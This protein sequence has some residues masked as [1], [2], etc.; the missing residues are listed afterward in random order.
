MT[1]LVVLLSALF[2]LCIVPTAKGIQAI[3]TKT[4]LSR[5]VHV[6]Q[7]QRVSAISQLL[8]IQQL[9]SKV[10]SQLLIMMVLSEASDM[11][12]RRSSGDRSSNSPDNR[13]SD[14]PAWDKPRRPNPES[15]D[16]RSSNE[17]VNSFGRNN[18]RKDARFQG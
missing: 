6:L 5:L 2:L 12:D 8:H 7:V 11:P 4:T 16:H 9:G 14:R 3:K 13:N 10:S 1:N 18:D 15:P 17:D